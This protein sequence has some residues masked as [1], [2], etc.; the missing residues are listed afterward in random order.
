MNKIALGSAQFGAHYGINNRRGK[1]PAN[2]VFEILDF[3]SASQI[4]LLDTAF[5][6]GESE[7]VIGYYER[8]H[9]C[10][11]K[12]VSKLPQCAG[13]EVKDLFDASLTRLHAKSLYG[14][15]IHNFK[16]FNEHPDIWRIL[17][18]L[19]AEGKI[20]KI[21]FSIYYPTELETLF[22]RNIRFDMI[23]FPYSIL[24]QRFTAYFSELKKRGIEIH[25]RSV[26]LQGLIFKE[27]AFLNEK[28]SK[29]KDTIT[30]IRSLAKDKGI[31]LVAL[32]VNFAALNEF[33]DKIIIGVD[34]LGNL[35]EIVSSRNYTSNVEEVL[36]QLATLR[37]DDET[38][39][40]PAKWRI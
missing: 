16:Y 28:F 8:A 10:P 12:I 30:Q 13:R 2:E 6:Y 40:V 34:S 35:K 17:E 29:I 19:K 24:D 36:S 38:M 1:I 18:I 9:G 39:I 22:K 15:L 5:E 37:E 14:Y 27:A 25:V 3:A 21:G 23:Q 31:S 4:D 7:N 26:F 33:I 32:C 11:F 20:E